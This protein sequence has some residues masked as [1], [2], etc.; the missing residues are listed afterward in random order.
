MPQKA[1]GHRAGRN[2][3]P[4]KVVFHRLGTFFRNIIFFIPFFFNFV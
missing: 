1:A 2:E 4:A 3:A